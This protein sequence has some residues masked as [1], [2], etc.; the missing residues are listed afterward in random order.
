MPKKKIKNSKIIIGTQKIQNKS[1]NNIISSIKVSSR[2]HRLEWSS[3]YAF[4]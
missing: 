2:E 1:I 3:D 4:F